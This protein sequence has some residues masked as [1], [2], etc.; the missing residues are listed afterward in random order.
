MAGPLIPRKPTIT[1]A[2]PP[3]GGTGA[4]TVVDLS[5]YVNAV[6]IGSEAET[7]DVATF[8][9]PG[10]TEIGKVTDS[11]VLSTLWSPELYDALQPHLNEEGDLLLKLN[12]SDTKGIQATVKYSN[13]PWGKFV[14]GERVEDDLTLAVLSAITYDTLPVVN[15]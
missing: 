2:F 12:E 15:P 3:A 5:C 9:N 4:D 6:D 7:I 14:A 10:A 8:C 13:L 1:I 11:I